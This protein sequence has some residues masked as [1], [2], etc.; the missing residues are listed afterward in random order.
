MVARIEELFAELVDEQLDNAQAKELVLL[1]GRDEGAAND[2]LDLLRTHFLLAE[3]CGPVTEF[4]IEELRAA[5]AIDDRFDQFVAVASRRHERPQSNL[6]AAWRFLAL[7]AS[8]ALVFVLWRSW[9]GKPTKVA[10]DSRDASPLQTANPAGDD[11]ESI[12]ARVR[13]KIDCDWAEDRWSVT[14]NGE[15]RE[16]QLITISKGLL[17]LQFGSGAE[18]TL[19]GPAT[20]SA[21]SKTSVKLVRGELSASVP[22]QARGFCVE[23]HAGDF[24]DLGTEFGLMVAED[25]DVETH[26]FKGE[27]VAEV[28]APNGL[29]DKIPLNTGDAW[30]GTSDGTLDANLNAEPDRFLRPLREQSLTLAADAMTAPPVTHGLKLRF[31]AEAA[32]Q[33]DNKGRVSEW[34]DLVDVR[35]NTRRENAWQVDPAL[36]PL[37]IENSIGSRP[38]LRFDGYRSLVTEP[39][40]LGSSQT[41]AVVFRA[42]G[43]VAQE[44]IADRSEFRELGVQILNLNGPP[45]TVL[46]LSQDLTLVGRVH[47]GYIPNHSDPVDVGFVKSPNSIDNE[48]HVLIYSFDT[49]GK[50]AR[51]FLDGKLVSETHDVPPLDATTASRFIGSHYDRPGFGFTGDIAEVLVYDDSLSSDDARQLSKWLGEKYSIAT[52][53]PKVAMLPEE[54]RE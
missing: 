33:R 8:V 32:V 4:S 31:V 25:G 51:M 47:L 41:S 17:V 52:A 46:Q 50:V 7:A 34:G 23:T 12:V 15:I 9:E 42:D 3:R 21:T 40:R 54:V 48:A 10:V 45:H 14:A 30:A 1:L 28:S 39:M 43:D 18:I 49:T 11:D 26:V 19:N 13:R 22:P 29:K 38:A 5:K 2:F 53:K 44:L 24:V 6:L 36:R 20:L 37:W 16:G 35:D 27:V